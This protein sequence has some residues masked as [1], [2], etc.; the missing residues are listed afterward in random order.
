VRFLKRRRIPTVKQH[1]QTDCGAACLASVGAYHRLHVPVARIRQLAGTDQHGTSL[2]G[3]IEAARRMGFTAKGVRATRD[4]L[5]SAPKPA[6]AHITLKGVMP[7]YVVVYE[8][9]ATQATVMDPYTGEVSVKTIDELAWS[10]ALLILQPGQEFKPGDARTS[11]GRRFAGL[12]RPHGTILTEALIGAVAYTLLGLSTAIYVQKVVDYVLADGNSRLLNL[13]SMI[14]IVLLVAQAYLGAAKNFLTLRTGQKIDAELVLGYYKHLLR[15]PQQFFDTM[16]VGEILSRINDAVKIRAFI[17]DVALDLMVNVLVV[18]FSLGLM[19]VY[20]WKLALMMMALFPVYGSI[21]LVTNRANR[22]NQRRMMESSADLESQ[23]VESLNGLP[24][25]KRFGLE[26]FANGKM[27]LSFVRVLRTVR[28]AAKTGILTG[29]TTELA[30]RVFAIVLLWVGAH[31]VL[32]REISPGELMSCYAL[33]GYLTGPIAS[34][35]GMNRTMQD[36]LIAADRLF[37]ILDLE[38]EPNAGGVM[39]EAETGDVRFEDV[40]FRYGSRMPVFQH[41][42]L[43]FRRGELTAVVGESGSGKSTI[44]ALVQRIYALEGGRVMIGDQDVRHVSP[45]SLRRAT[46]IVPQQIDLF[47]GSIMENIAVGEYEPDRQRVLQVSRDLG[48]L[49][50]IQATPGGFE[51]LV[52]ENG[53]ALSGGQRQRLAIAR[54]LYRDPSILILDEATSSLD[55]HSEQFVQRTMQTL[56]QQ[57]KTVVVIAHRLSS[58]VHADRIVVLDRGK[59]AEEGTHTELLA[60]GGAYAQLWNAQFPAPPSADAKPALLPF[61]AL[62]HSGNGNGNGNGN[63]AHAYAGAR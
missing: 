21:Y 38:R 35:I 60:R 18:T 5:A 15:L 33:I 10:G 30:G 50:F 47:S 51:S 19:F 39:L 3:L 45:E 9:T 46:A 61:T 11:I 53:V 57:G 13:M 28:T 52:G 12:L 6:I 54:A 32:A 43:T 24:T 58:V 40:T 29:T 56:R 27:E 62:A 44:A 37:E 31:F 2:L 49:D 16:R 25:V 59:V 23:L 4:G 14:M 42:N 22:R 26:R 55:P 20:S 34:L 41:L 36:A 8:A 1:D 63:G 7:H 48:I 17:N